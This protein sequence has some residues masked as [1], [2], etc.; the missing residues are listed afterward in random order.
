M[1]EERI[2]RR[3]YEDDYISPRYDEHRAAAKNL[4]D[5][6][7]SPTSRRTSG[8]T[9]EKERRAREYE[10]ED[11]ARRMAEKAKAHK[12]F[13]QSERRRT[14]ERRRDHDSKYYHAS[15]EEPSDS[16]SDSTERTASSRRPELRRSYKDNRRSTR[17]ELP[18]RSKYDD[19]DYEDESESRTQSKVK[20]AADYIYQ[21]SGKTLYE[22]DDRR[23]PSLTKV[24]TGHGRIPPPPPPPQPSIPQSPPKDSRARP[25]TYSRGVREPGR[26][27]S[28]GRDRRQPEI[29]DPPIY[30][31]RRP[32]LNTTT[33][34]PSNIKLPPTFSNPKLPRVKTMETRPSELRVPL[35]PKRAQTS[36][37]GGMVSPSRHYETAPPKSSKLRNAETHD[38]GYSSP[39][40]PETHHGASPHFTS[41]K[42]QY[43]LSELDEDDELPSP[44][45]VPIEPEHRRERD[46]SPHSHHRSDRPPPS[47][48]TASH[49]RIPLQ[50]S[51]T[52]APE[53]VPSRPP[54][55]SRTAS[56]RPHLYG[57]IDNPPVQQYK[58]HNFSPKLVPS[59]IQYSHARR[60]SERGSARDHRDAYSYDG[61]RSGRGAHP[62]MGGRGGSYV[63]Q[64]SV[65]A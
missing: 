23:R 40:T 28:S 33:S 19:S 48:R 60:N 65:R 47:A 29:V 15:V 61:S 34:A 56:S 26:P 13:S 5:R 12:E 59:D 57:A 54:P 55:V 35:P 27:T 39:G 6:Y 24:H 25:S 41:T 37:L 32:A 11:K 10:A 14:K 53:P 4:D 38:S 64:E 31:P 58:V 1:Y 44:R 62:G 30:E 51:T 8:R 36:P 16:D 9:S 7:D 20:T 3:S 2:P 46:L 22:I 63:K 42:Y 45:I 50:R 21:A 49:V 17:E 43:H 52:Y 18:T